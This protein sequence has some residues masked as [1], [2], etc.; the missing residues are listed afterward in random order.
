MLPL[1]LPS[2]VAHRSL[3]ANGPT[4]SGA[5]RLVPRRLLSPFSRR[6]LS[7]RRPPSG[8]NTSGVSTCLHLILAPTP[9][10][11]YFLCA[12]PRPS[13]PPGVRYRLSCTG[14]PPEFDFCLTRSL[15]PGRLPLTPGAAPQ[16]APSSSSPPILEVTCSR[17]PGVPTARRL[18][19]SA[20]P[21]VLFAAYGVVEPFCSG[22]VALPGR[23]GVASRTSPQVG[24]GPI[25]PAGAYLVLM[26]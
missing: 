10:P 6:H 5:S 26:T 1:I 20:Y 16:Y 21:L 24:H 2:V 12:G 3:V 8:I 25:R 22:V 9:P 19:R 11:L 4:I 15:L 14:G 17:L 7:S 13:F 23:G 18:R